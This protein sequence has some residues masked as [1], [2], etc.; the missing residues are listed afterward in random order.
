MAN[1]EFSAGDW[2]EARCTKC[3]KIT[4]HTVVAMT[5]KGP[6]Q[7]RCETCK[8]THKYRPAAAPKKA[9]ATGPTARKASVQ[10]E[11]SELLSGMDSSKAENYSMEGD[12]RVKSLIRHPRF[13]LG[14]VQRIA[15]VRK[16]EVL[17]ED[18]KKMLR[19]K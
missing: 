3:R 14:L 9:A 8:G 5:D 11:W 16:V 1:T 7:V 12:Y 18:G 4:N 6:A 10:K 17:F 2:I 13:G 19:C 15:G